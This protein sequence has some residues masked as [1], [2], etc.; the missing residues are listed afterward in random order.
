[1][2][3]D[4]EIALALNALQK[5]DPT[6]RLRGVAELRELLLARASQEGGSDALRETASP[7]LH[8]Y[9]RLWPQDAEPRVREGLQRCLQALV[10]SLQRD[11]AR[12]LR[13]AFPTWLCAMFDT[14]AEVA[15]GARKAFIAS[16]SSDDKRRGVFRHCQA[17]CFALLTANLRH[18][19]QSLHDELGM[20]AA[21]ASDRN[22]AL[23][24]QDRYAR[25][26]AASL[27]GLG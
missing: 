20:S 13:G 17:E 23:E 1:M 24:R 25:V 11:F 12:H 15:Q 4:A 2:P 18:S 21:A 6:T 3:G 9:R 10:E 27:R 7:F 22:A 5:K 26:V 8:I 16:F 14:H 19:E